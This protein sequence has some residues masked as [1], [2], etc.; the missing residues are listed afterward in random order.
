MAFT[1]GQVLEDVR[2]ILND[3]NSVHWTLPELL[4]WINDG[5]KA[6]VTHK[7]TA[8]ATDVEFGLDEGTRQELAATQAALLSINAVLTQVEGG[9]GRIRGNSVTRVAKHIL[10]AQ[11]PGWQNPDVLP[12]SVYVNHYVFQPEIDPRVFWIAPGNDGTGYVEATVAMLPTVIAKPLNPLDIES[13]TT[14]VD[15]PDIYRPPLTDYVLYRAFSKDSN[16]PGG[17]QRA[18]GHYNQFASMLGI[19]T[20]AEMQRDERNAAAR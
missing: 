15:L 18:V 16:I 11:I 20:Q 6:I 10:D 5:A 17:G 19:K 12:Y 9:G 1:C 13:Y 4:N 3:A 7:P 14:A 2:A 8:T